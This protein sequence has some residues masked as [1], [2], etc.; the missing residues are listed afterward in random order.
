M[1]HENSLQIG[2]REVSDKWGFSSTGVSRAHTPEPSIDTI[3]ETG[4][5]EDPGNVYHGRRARSAGVP[6]V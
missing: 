5:A 6:N 2:D 1:W 4:R 3:G